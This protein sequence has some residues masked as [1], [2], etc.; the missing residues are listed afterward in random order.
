MERRAKIWIMGDVQRGYL[1]NM[2]MFWFITTVLSLISIFFLL[3]YLQNQ[4]AADHQWVQ[5]FWEYFKSKGN[6]IYIFFGIHFL[7]SLLFGVYFFR[8]FTL[9]ICGPIHNLQN[10]LQVI[11]TSQE[12][13]E[14]PREIRIRKTDYFQKLAYEINELLRHRK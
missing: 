1:F 7:I 11:N 12:Q 13:N 9:R 14:G 2:I 3:V 8:K 10:Q 4:S 5:D 6:L